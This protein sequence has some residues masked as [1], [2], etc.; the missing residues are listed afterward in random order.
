MFTY[1]HDYFCS[2]Y[3]V[4]TWIGCD[5]TLHLSKVIG[6]SGYCCGLFHSFLYICCACALAVS[7]P[8]VTGRSCVH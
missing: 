5:C 8:F 2:L 3:S 7:V 1:E 6:V 4:F